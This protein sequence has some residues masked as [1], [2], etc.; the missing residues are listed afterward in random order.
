MTGLRFQIGVGNV[1]S[2]NTAGLQMPKIVAERF[3]RDQ[4]NR[5]RVS[6]KR[7]HDQQIELLRRLR[8]E[9]QAR[10][11]HFQ[12]AQK[13]RTDWKNSMQVVHTADDPPNQGRMILAMMGCT[14]NKRN[15]ERKIVSA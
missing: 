15:A 11:S 10:V 13:E 4:V 5:R 2:H 8:L 6:G 12:I 3:A 14:W 7:I 1:H 9:R